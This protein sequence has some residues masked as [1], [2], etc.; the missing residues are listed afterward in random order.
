MPQWAQEAVF[1][2]VPL[3]FLTICKASLPDALHAAPLP[4]FTANDPGSLNV[5]FRAT[6]SVHSDI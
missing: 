5:C 2:A 4:G 6:L 3:S 1:A